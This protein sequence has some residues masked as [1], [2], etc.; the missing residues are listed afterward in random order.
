MLELIKGRP[1]REQIRAD[2]VIFRWIP[3]HEV[4]RTF[5]SEHYFTLEIKRR[6][7]VIARGIEIA[8]SCI[9]F[10]IQQPLID[11]AIGVSHTPTE[12]EP[13][14]LD[15]LLCP[16]AKLRWAAIFHLSFAISILVEL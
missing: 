7:L 4:A 9:H 1:Q 12:D 10:R 15:H 6:A 11:S 2:R 5:V 8:E 16:F 14:R 3:W 13:D